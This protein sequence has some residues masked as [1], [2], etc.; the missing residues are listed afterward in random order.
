MI[1]SRSGGCVHPTIRPSKGKATKKKKTQQ[2]NKQQSKQKQ[3]IYKKCNKQ[4]LYGQCLSPRPPPHFSPSPFNKTNEGTHNEEVFSPNQK[5]AG[6][7]KISTSKEMHHHRRKKKKKRKKQPLQQ[8]ATHT[9]R[10]NRKTEGSKKEM[11]LLRDFPHTAPSPPPPLPLSLSPPCYL[12]P[13]FSLVFFYMFAP[14]S[15]TA[16]PIPLPPPHFLPPPSLCHP[17][18][19]TTIRQPII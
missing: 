13:F 2:Q 10:H 4:T 15:S 8:T 18:P 11:C 17:T 6:T 5:S 16:F 14:P 12:P 19:P 3:R 9:Q 7:I 1:K